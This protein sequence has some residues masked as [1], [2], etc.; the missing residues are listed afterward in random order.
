MNEQA[1]SGHIVPKLNK[2]LILIGKI[3]D[4]NYTAVFTNKDIKI[5]KSPIQIPENEILLTGHRDATNGLYITDLD[6]KNIHILQIKLII[7]KMLRPKIPSRFYIWKRLV[8]LYLH[9]LKQ[10]KKAFSIRGQG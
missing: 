4:A 10:F 8:Q 1:K 5:S 2:S 3:C 9:E 7:C 6:N